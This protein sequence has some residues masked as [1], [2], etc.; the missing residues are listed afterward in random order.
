VPT[1]S[2]TI[3]GHHPNHVAQALAEAKIAVWSGSSYAVEAVDQLGLTESG[4]VVRAGVTRY[5]TAHDVDRLLEVVTSLAS[6]R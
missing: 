5:V 3:R 1:V 6:N 2:F 4:G